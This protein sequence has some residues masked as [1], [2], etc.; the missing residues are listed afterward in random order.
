MLYSCGQVQCPKCG[1]DGKIIEKYRGIE[2]YE[3]P[4][5]YEGKEDCSR[6][7]GRGMVYCD[8]KGSVVFGSRTDKAICKNGVLH[9]KYNWNFGVT[10]PEC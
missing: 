4:L 6:C 2:E 1:G 7:K 5:N 3:V 9:T 10:C 8:Y